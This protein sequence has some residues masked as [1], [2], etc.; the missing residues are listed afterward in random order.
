MHQG[1]ICPITRQCLIS[2]GE[3]YGHIYCHA[4]LDKM[5]WHAMVPPMLWHVLGC[6]L[7]WC[8]ICASVSY[9]PGCNMGQPCCALA[10]QLAN[11]Q[12]VHSA[13]S[14]MRPTHNYTT[15]LRGTRA[16]VPVMLPNCTGLQCPSITLTWQSSRAVLATAYVK[17]LQTEF[18]K[19][20]SK[21]FRILAQ[22]V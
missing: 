11:W 1:A 19:P 6:N 16:N 12:T 3:S 2:S 18:I 7:R 21:K 17:L 15:A 8:A 5:G 20:F 14:E 13:V 4:S 10:F 22:C 9:G